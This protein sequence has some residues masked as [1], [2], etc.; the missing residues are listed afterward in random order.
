MGRRSHQYKKMK[1]EGRRGGEGR[2]GGGRREGRGREEG[3]R[4][5]GGKGEREEK[6]RRGEKERGI[7]KRERRK[8]EGVRAGCSSQ[9]F[10]HRCCAGC[11]TPSRCPGSV[12]P[13]YWETHLPRYSGQMLRQTSP[14]N[15]K[16]TRTVKHHALARKA[17]TQLK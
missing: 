15:R 4:R 5:E 3:G 2:K 13:L 11:H 1:E 7:Q 14:T 17:C 10:R 12:V 6:R 9:P 8:V 16:I